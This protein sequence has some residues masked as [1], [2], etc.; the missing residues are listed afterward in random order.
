MWP[1]KA[2]MEHLKSFW[3]LF[4][5][6]FSFFLSSFKHQSTVLD[7]DCLDQWSMNKEVLNIWD[8]WEIYFK[9][10]ALCRNN[11]GTEK[12]CS[13][14]YTYWSGVATEKSHFETRWQIIHLGLQLLKV[15]RHINHETIIWYSWAGRSQQYIV[16][17]EL[18][19][20]YF[21]SK[22]QL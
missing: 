20:S 15:L 8:T 14:Q 18:C 17:K 16:T 12:L 2:T 5:S 13:P 9:S 21:W 19:V 10:S 7:V 3:R 6:F 11:A 4:F 1:S 22:I